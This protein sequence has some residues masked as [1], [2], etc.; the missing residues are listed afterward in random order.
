MSRMHKPG[1]QETNTSQ[2]IP[3]KNSTA[4]IIAIDDSI[5]ATSGKYGR[6]WMNYFEDMKTRACLEE[7][8]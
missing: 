2:K 5:A 1:F 4:P 8:F 3:L 6:A 7:L